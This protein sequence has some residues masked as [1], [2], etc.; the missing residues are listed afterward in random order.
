MCMPLF[1]MH[2]GYDQEAEIIMMEITC[3]HHLAVLAFIEVVTADL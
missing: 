2:Q 1:L 3:V